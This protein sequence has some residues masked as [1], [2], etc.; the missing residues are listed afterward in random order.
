M[1]MLPKR[2]ALESLESRETPT[3]TVVNALT[4]TYTDVD[5]DRVTITSSQGDLHNAGFFFTAS[6]L[7]EQLNSVELNGGFGF[8]GTNLSITA[9]KSPTGDG[10]VNVGYIHSANNLGAVKVA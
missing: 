4:A 7:G 2:L 5:G 1:R 9:A 3:V 8:S 6:A 10:L